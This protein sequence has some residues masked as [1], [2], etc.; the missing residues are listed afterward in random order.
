MISNSSIANTSGILAWSRVFDCLDKDLYG[1]LFRSEVD[2]FEGVFN[3]IDD[4]CL[5]SRATARAHEAIYESLHDVDFGLAKFSMFMSAHAVRSVNWLKRNVPLNPW[6]HY[7]S[8]VE[9]PLS[10]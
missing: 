6:V 10:E 7:L 5:F 2:D 8:L 9:T 1:V 3:Q 4:S